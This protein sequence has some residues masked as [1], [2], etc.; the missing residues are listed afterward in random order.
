MDTSDPDID[1]DDAGVCNHCRFFD[2]EL[3]KN[4]YPNQHGRRLLEA[5]VDRIK[6][7][8]QDR[9]Y[10]CVIGLSGGIDSSYLAYLARRELGLRPLAIHVDGGWN[11]ELAVRNIEG[12]VKC[13]DIDLHTHVVDW[14]EM[15]DLQRA[16]LRAGLAN[17]DVPQ[18]HAFISGLYSQA[19]SHGIRHVLSGGNIATESILPAE[20]A[21]N[22]MDLRHL[23]AIHRRFGE[24]PLDTFPTVN[25][26]Q[27]Y[28]WYPVVKRMT[29]LR[30]LNFLPYN[31]DE[32]IRILERET[33]FCYYG[34]KHFES[35]FTKWQ[36]LHYRP[37]K[38]GYDERRAYLSS[39]ILSGQMRRDAALGA[40]AEPG[41]TTAQLHE[42]TDFVRRKLGFSAEEFAQI[43]G[44]PPRT[45]R[46][47]PSNHRLFRFKDTLKT[48][49][50][51]LGIRFRRRS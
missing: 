45:F 39:L 8:N 24:R 41:Y 48:R 40:I 6:A 4:W 10:D 35:R 42:D 20:W 37:H 22:A 29:V 3:T 46:E 34:G 50:A 17:Q 18:D 5:T 16:F 23:R 26:F 27:F 14:E 30:P 21:Y 13:L 25:F 32:A 12:I 47:Y 1:F 7:E 43:L 28:F 31:R 49:L 19:I 51:A 15:R 33:G 2:L 38:F 11:S 36:Q 44:N 9:E